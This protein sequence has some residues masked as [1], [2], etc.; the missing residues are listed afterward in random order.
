M[1]P[2][3]D[4]SGRRRSPGGVGAMHIGSAIHRSVRAPPRQPRGDCACAG[5]RKTGRRPTGRGF[6][7]GGIAVRRDCVA[8][9]PQPRAPSRP[10]HTWQGER[11]EDRRRK[12]HAGEGAAPHRRDAPNGHRKGRDR[13]AAADGAGAHMQKSRGRARMKSRV[14]THARVTRPHAGV[15]RPRAKARASL[16]PP[17]RVKTRA[18]RV[19]QAPTREALTTA[20]G[21]TLGAALAALGTAL[22]GARRGAQLHWMLTP[23][24]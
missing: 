8:A 12:T 10:C 5:G 22:G 19:G 14:G 2:S 15:T 7:E 17:T 24:G 11:R 20:L 6:C 16:G 3:A 1:L 13:G 4:K 18:P 9:L 21:E 23:V